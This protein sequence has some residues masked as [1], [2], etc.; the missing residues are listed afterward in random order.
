MVEGNVSV[1]SYGAV[2]LPGEYSNP[3]PDD[4]EAGRVMRLSIRSCR[5]QPILYRVSIKR[6]LNQN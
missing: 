6:M 1:R 4:Y 3:E 5:F 2:P